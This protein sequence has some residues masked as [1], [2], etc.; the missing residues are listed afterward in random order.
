MRGQYDRATEAELDELEAAAAR[1]LEYLASKG[2]DHA[3]IS[4][5]RGSRLEVNVRMGEVDLVKEAASS[6][7]S[8]RVVV[9]ERVATSST[10]DMEPE[11]VQAFLDRVVE[12]AELS[13]PDPL[14][15]PPD[16][17]ELTKQGRELD[18]F[19]PKTA[20]ITAAQG[21]K[22]AMTAEKTALRNK[23]I[24]A[25]DGATFSRGVGSSVLATS[26]GFV[27]RHAGSSQY[28]VAHVIA[29]DEGGKKR[30]GYAW[31]SARHF[32]DLE[33]PAA[34]GERAARKA[35]ARLGARKMDTGVYPIV[36]DKDVSRAML[37]LLAS[38]ILGGAVYREQSYLSGRLGTVV[39]SP[40]VTITDDPF[41]P[42]APGSRPFDGEGR[43]GRRNVVVR[44]G[45]LE[46]FLLDTYSARKLKMDPTGSG[47]GGG[48]V[49]HST[50][51]NFV[52][53][54]GR[55]APEKLLAGIERGLFVTSMMGYGFNAVTG[56]F[57]R[58]AEGF[59]IVDGKLGDPVGEITISRPLDEI[60]Q[61]I[62]M[63]AN[64]LEY[65]SSITA[66]SF[67]VDKMTVSGR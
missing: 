15:V 12:M 38:C 1:A 60:L 56:D 33:T 37:S 67:R 9:D 5:A 43:A 34:I 16:P 14:S 17:S 8:V 10:N 40:L 4:A 47:G 61:G 53:Q 24:T 35:V 41:L 65:R 32:A 46:S 64:D 19:D 26:G 49:P 48:G 13:E 27:G 28:L 3:E 52:M 36:F 66:P 54:P 2:V 18:L 55:H 50:V 6:G 51:S 25:S 63:V 59:E 22:M 31:T 29:D 7:L 11:A 23:A 30:N 57:S 20:K 42:R 44:R 45:V 62:D 21:I 58:G 39:A